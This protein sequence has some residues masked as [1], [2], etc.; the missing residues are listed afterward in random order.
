MT[1]RQAIAQSDALASRRCHRRTN[2]TD[3]WGVILD[4]APLMSSTGAVP[5]HYNRALFEKAVGISSATRLKHNIY[6]TKCC[7]DT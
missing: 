1:S 5:S 6:E 2:A 4:D 7:D 3:G